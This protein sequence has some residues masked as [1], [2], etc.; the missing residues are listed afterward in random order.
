M[1]V[2]KQKVYAYITHRNRLLV[3]TQPETLDES[4][5]QV[6]GG[7]MDPGERPEEAVMRE[8][9][10]ETGLTGLHLVRFLSSRDRDFRQYGDEPIHQEIHH[11]HFFHLTCTEAPPERW[12]HFEQHPS[13]GSPGPIRFTLFW[14]SLPDGVPALA[15]EMDACLPELMDSL[16]RMSATKSA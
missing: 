12:D 15:G 9:Y 6:P 5:V 10:E 2:H 14:A 8:A 1:L 16:R 13:D 7:T 11:R 4:G 3:F